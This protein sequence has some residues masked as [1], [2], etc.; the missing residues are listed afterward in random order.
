MQACKAG[1]APPNSSVAASVGNHAFV[2]EGMPPFLQSL[3]GS[4][5]DPKS[6]CK[7]LTEKRV[8]KRFI[9]SYRLRIE[10]DYTFRGDASGLYGGED[11]YPSFMRYLRKAKR[12][13]L[14]PGEEDFALMAELTLSEL[15]CIQIRGFVLFKLNL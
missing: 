2:A 8:Y 10:D 15:S 14:M 5:G 13:G 11:P 6:W 1:V 12:K 9:D 3:G 7:G 4:R